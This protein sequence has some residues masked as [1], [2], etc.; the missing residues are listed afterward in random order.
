MPTSNDHYTE[1]LLD[2]N[3]NVIGPTKRRPEKLLGPLPTKV[4]W[5]GYPF[6]TY[7]GFLHPVR[8]PNWAQKTLLLLQLS[9]QRLTGLKKCPP[10]PPGHY[11][12]LGS[13]SAFKPFPGSHPSSG[14]AVQNPR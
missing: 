2:S 4:S 7:N 6:E 9:V 14:K 12:D 5:I 11:R 8:G 10:G 1:S 3:A 13:R